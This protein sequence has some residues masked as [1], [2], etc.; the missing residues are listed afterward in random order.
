MSQAK[1]DICKGAQI[2]SLRVCEG[3]G[4]EGV[5]PRCAVVSSK[6]SGGR[7]TAMSPLNFG[8]GLPV[9]IRKS[10]LRYRYVAGWAERGEKGACAG[11][12]SAFEQRAKAHESA[13]ATHTSRC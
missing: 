2:T 3:G 13:A 9:S 1:E 8:T 12:T 6:D 10:L 7:T 5:R 4:A 11:R